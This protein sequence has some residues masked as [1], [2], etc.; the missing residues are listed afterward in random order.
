MV[1]MFNGATSFNGDISRWDVSSVTLMWGMFDGAQSLNID[2]SKWDVSGVIDMKSMFRFATSFNGDISKWDVSSVTDM[3]L[4]FYGAT[5]FNRDISKWDVSSVKSMA[6]MFY[7]TTS[8][9]H[10]LCGDAWAR[11]RARKSGMFV[12]SSGS[13]TRAFTISC[14]SPSDLD[15]VLRG[16]KFVASQ[17]PNDVFLEFVLEF[18]TGKGSKLASVMNMVHTFVAPSGRGRGLAEAMTLHAFQHCIQKKMKVRPSCSYIN[19]RFLDQHPAFRDICVR[20]EILKELKNGA[21]I[22]R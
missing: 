14:A 20:I 6:R 3:S 7:G 2:I 21:I 17:F 15:V 19:G 13:I 5:S 10:T 11:S 18:G 8:F 4:M 22:N 1:G 16:K 9:M 12:R